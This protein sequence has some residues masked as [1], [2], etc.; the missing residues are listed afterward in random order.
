MRK[1]DPVLFYQSQKGQA[2]VGLLVVMREAYSDP[3]SA[4]PQW[5]TCDFQPIHPQTSDSTPALRKLDAHSNL[6]LFRQ[7]RLAVMPL[8][9]TEFQQ[10]ITVS[11][12]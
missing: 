5:L 2:V 6:A 9:Q 12:L 10:I 11:D 7:P 1:G 8:S 4:D 3:V